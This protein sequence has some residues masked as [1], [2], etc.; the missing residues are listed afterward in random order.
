MKHLAG[1]PY[2]FCT[3]ITMEP[4]IFSCGSERINLNHRAGAVN[5]RMNS[6]WRRSE[7]EFA[8]D[9]VAMNHQPTETLPFERVLCMFWQLRQMPCTMHGKIILRQLAVLIYLNTPTI[10][11][12]RFSCVVQNALF[13]QMHAFTFQTIENTE[14]VVRFG[15]EILDLNC[16]RD[17]GLQWF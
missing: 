10:L 6:T 14:N 7:I 11:R 4:F 9:N 12:L 3:I 2:L 5:L 17:Y 15:G 13:K 8:E 1:T 16:L